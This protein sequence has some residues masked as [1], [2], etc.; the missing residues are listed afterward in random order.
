MLES[1]FNTGNIVKW[2]GIITVL[3]TGLIHAIETPE[4]FEASAYIGILF[5]LNVVGSIIA[6]VGI[7]QERFDWG[8]SL[9]LLITAGAFIMFIIS[10]TVGLPD[11]HADEWDLMGIASL[12]VEGIYTITYIV[13]ATNNAAITAS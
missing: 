1:T 9:G 11:F 12:V 7:W 3:L 6:A 13:R 10:R 5:I 8:W 2:V 4:H